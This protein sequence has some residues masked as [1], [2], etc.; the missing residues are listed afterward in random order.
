MISRLAG[1]DSPWKK[2]NPYKVV[3]YAEPLTPGWASRTGG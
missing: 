1:V 3:L 2:G